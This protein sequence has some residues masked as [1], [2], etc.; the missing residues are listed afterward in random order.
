MSRFYNQMVAIVLSYFMGFC[1]IA[2]VV[3]QPGL[4]QYYMKTAVLDYNYQNRYNYAFW[5]PENQRGFFG[6]EMGSEPVRTLGM[7]AANSANTFN[8]SLND[9][10]YRWEDWGCYIYEGE[11]YLEA[12]KTYTFC[13]AF[14]DGA[15]LLIGG[16]VVVEPP[17]ETSISTSTGCLGTFQPPVSG[18]YP[19]TGYVWDFTVTKAPSSHVL[20][21]I[22]WTASDDASAVQNTARRKDATLWQRFMDSGDGSFL[23]CPVGETPNMTGTITVAATHA[24]ANSHVNPV[25]GTYSPS[26]RHPVEA[27]TL[28]AETGFLSGNDTYVLLGCIVENS[29]DGI[30]WTS[31]VTNYNV[32]SYLAASNPHLQEKVTWLY[33]RE[34]DSRTLYVNSKVAIAEN[35]RDGMSSKSAFH[36][37]APAIALAR[38]LDTIQKLGNGTN[39]VDATTRFQGC[40]YA[41][42]G[43]LKIKRGITSNWFRW[44]VRRTNYGAS[45]VM[46]ISELKFF[47]VNGTR[48]GLNL[49]STDPG[50]DP[51]AMVPGSFCK[52]TNF[53]TGKNEDVDKLFD[54]N[55]S[56]KLC[57]IDANLSS[58]FNDTN[59]WRTITMRF[60]EDTP[61]IGSYLMTTAN[62]A[63][64][65]SPTSWLLETSGDGIHWVTVDDKLGLSQPTSFYSDFNGGEPYSVETPE[66]WSVTFRSRLE[67]APGAKILVSDENIALSALQVDCTTGAGILEGGSFAEEGNLYL[68]GTDKSISMIPIQIQ[69]ITNPEH[70]SNW[71]VYWNGKIQRRWSVCWADGE[72]WLV[73][74]AENLL[75]IQ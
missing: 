74:R 47:D 3:Y 14:D 41:Q 28:T 21:G 10:T 71:T 8:N 54:N 72:L 58:G 75:I 31:P 44:T 66:D 16:K 50:T 20:A 49:T 52:Q 64:Q 26:A 59:N 62:D 38:D 56:T 37:M 27:L 13:V 1:A 29:V 33:L 45:S 61:P 43:T 19:M 73:K 2:E 4:L 46:Q 67:V 36:V 48:Q 57:I 25:A 51:T 70:I 69:G 9:A 65:R 39:D 12:D 7:I 11:I 15:A 63:L 24:V 42:E 53:S 60:A 6:A 22:Q 40:F 34:A 55:T 32:T 35:L 23:R 17:P 5:M 18:W 30:N 68:K